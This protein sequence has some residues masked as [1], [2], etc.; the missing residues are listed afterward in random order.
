M[1]KGTVNASVVIKPVN[2]QT[3]QLKISGTAPLVINAFS[4]KAQTKM[5]ESHI[6]GA[7]ARSK[8]VREAKNPAELL[9][10][11]QHFGLDAEGNKFTGIP[12]TA[13]RHAMVRAA[14]LVNFKMT[15]AKQAIFIEPD[16]LDIYTGEGLI[17]IES[18]T[19]P[20]MGI[21]HVRNSSGV[22]DI[23]IRPMWREWGANVKI[24]FD[25]DMFTLEDV[26]N[27][28]NRAGLQVGI[29]EGR[30]FSKDS[31]GMGWGHF[32]IS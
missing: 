23:R 32:M 28:L 4:N 3:A 5:L 19:E 29:C 27:L 8:K 16:G 12:C 21:H 15:L 13:F 6:S 14:S 25:A 26:T 2:L 30:A 31:V 20:E 22:A 7:T 11:A 18:R 10:S 9:I 24:K 17:K 1:T